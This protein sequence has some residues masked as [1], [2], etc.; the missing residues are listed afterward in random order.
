M[1]AFARLFVSSL[2]LA[3]ASLPAFGQATASSSPGL[4]V[5][6]DGG[7]IPGATVVVKNNDRRYSNG[8]HELGWQVRNSIPRRRHATVT[9][10]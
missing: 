10:C 3:L 2:M 5:D 4:A 7:V 1:K 9:V 8:R 6:A